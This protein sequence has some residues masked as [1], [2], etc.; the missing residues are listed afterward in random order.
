MTMER[1]LP[2]LVAA[3]ICIHGCMTG[4]RMAAPL[5]ALRTYDSAMIAGILIALFAVSQVFFALPA[6]RFVDRHGLTRPIGISVLLACLGASVAALHPAVYTLALG[7]LL[8][9]GASGL[10]VIA[11]Q[12]HIGQ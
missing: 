5:W 12:R 6:G 2:R 4:L 8:T 9:G 7:A 3:Q 1:Q 10:T 11:L